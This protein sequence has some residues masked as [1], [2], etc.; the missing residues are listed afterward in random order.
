M[1]WLILIG[2]TNFGMDIIKSINH[3]GSIASYDVAEIDGQ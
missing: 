3:Y 1:K 2:D